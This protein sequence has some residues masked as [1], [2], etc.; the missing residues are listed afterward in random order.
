MAKNIRIEKF[1]GVTVKVVSREKSYSVFIN[2]APGTYLWRNMANENGYVKFVIPHDHCVAKRKMRFKVTNQT[3]N[4]K[5]LLLPF[6]K[7]FDFP[8]GGLCIVYLK[9]HMFLHDSLQPVD[10]LQSIANV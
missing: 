10:P 5:N 2:I 9:P 6:R 1:N 8:R 3:Y 4:R 7:T